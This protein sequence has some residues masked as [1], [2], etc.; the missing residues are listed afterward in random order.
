MLI[1]I[2]ISMLALCSAKGMEEDVQNF[3]TVK[4]MKT[5]F[6]IP[7][8]HKTAISDIKSN[9][10]RSEGIPIEQQKLIAVVPA[11]DCYFKR[12]ADLM[13]TRSDDLANDAT[14][15]EIVQNYGIDVH[16]ELYLT[17]HRNPYKNN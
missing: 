12:L 2:L 13:A 17:L 7:Y 4:T 14:I 3:I 5:S 11:V 1:C 10:Q 6:E 9:L 15:Q 16:F 8:N